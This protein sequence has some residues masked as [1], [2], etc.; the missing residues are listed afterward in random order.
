MCHV[1]LNADACDFYSEIL[2]K[3][4]CKNVE[5][6]VEMKKPQG[7]AGLFIDSLFFF[8]WH[9]QC[10]AVT[11]KDNSF[12]GGEKKKMPDLSL[13]SCRFWMH[14]VTRWEERKME[15]VFHN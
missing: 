3:I 2:N 5:I 10:Y 13:K 12:F 15:M 1:T 7:C 6:F 8:S 14:L 4:N 11:H 9:I